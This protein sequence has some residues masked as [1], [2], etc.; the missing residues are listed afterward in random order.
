MEVAYCTVEGRVVEGRF[1][2]VEDMDAGPG[3]KVVADIEAGVE[4]VQE[5]S[6]VSALGSYHLPDVDRN[7]SVAVLQGMLVALA[8]PT[9]GTV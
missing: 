4:V 1:A 8:F 7:R 6:T 3:A 5:H 9:F 2:V